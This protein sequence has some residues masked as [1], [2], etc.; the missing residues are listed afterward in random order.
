MWL[1]K[2]F[3][4]NLVDEVAG[5]FTLHRILRY[6]QRAIVRGRTAETF[7]DLFSGDPSRFF[8]PVPQPVAW[9]STQHVREWTDGTIVEDLQFPSIVRSEFPESDVVRLRRWR[10]AAGPVNHTV[11]G[12]DGVVQLGPQNFDRLARMVVPHGVEVVMMQAPFNF[13]RAPKGYAPGQLIMGG[14]LD[15]QLSVFRQAV[16]D[17]WTVISTLQAE[18]RTVGLVGISFGGWLSLTTSL[19][20]AGVDFVIA[21]VPPI[22]MFHILV[23]GGT[24][25]RAARRGM[26]R[27]QRTRAELA[28][29]SLP[30]SPLRWP[31]RLPPERVV[32]HLAEFDRFVPNNRIEQLAAAWKTQLVRHVDGHIGV[33]AQGSC[34]GDVAKQ[35]IEFSKTPPSRTRH[36][37]DR[38]QPSPTGLGSSLRASRNRAT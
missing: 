19:H 30:L 31:C 9:S 22:E 16:L 27:E 21:L 1:W 6:R 15:H 26:D 33:A 10:P 32:L 12:I 20:A 8:Q 17:L 36:D 7:P 4:S 34:L 5:L 11:I 23:E 2:R 3:R 24:V 25:V 35:V 14:D 18:G 37:S 13:R 29:I 28:Q 38:P